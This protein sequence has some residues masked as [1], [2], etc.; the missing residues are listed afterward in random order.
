MLVACY[1]FA[2]VGMQLGFG[3]SY[4]RFVTEGSQIIAYQLL[5]LPLWVDPLPP[6]HCS[7]GTGFYYYHYYYYWSVLYSAI[8]CSWADSLC[9]CCLWFSMSNYILFFLL[10]A[11]FS[12]SN[13]VMYWQHYLVVTSYMAGAMWNCCHISASLHNTTMHQ[14]TLSLY[15]KMHFWQNDQDVLCITVVTL[16]EWIL[17]R[18]CREVDR[19][20][21]KMFMEGFKHRI[22]QSRVRCSNPWAI[23]APT[24]DGE[25]PPIPSKQCLLYFSQKNFFCSLSL[26]YLFNGRSMCR[27]MD[28]GDLWL[29]Q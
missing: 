22:F 6:P 7:P 27:H 5:T 19:C 28:G 4:K 24:L 20:W 14:F 12:I 26:L 23:P 1:F 16:V 29:M 13:E 17:K 10:T 25:N 9:S 11:H 3:L 15:S 18:V 8:L 21:K 2:S